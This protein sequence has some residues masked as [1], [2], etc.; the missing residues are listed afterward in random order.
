MTK[1][2]SI[3]KKYQKKTLKEHIETRPG[4]Y[5]GTIELCTQNLWVLNDDNSKMIQ[6]I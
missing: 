1:S 6:K 5:I 3:E 2:I 4:N